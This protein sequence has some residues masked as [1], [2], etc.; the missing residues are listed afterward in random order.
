M[1]G[2]SSINVD[3]RLPFS[4]KSGFRDQYMGRPGSN[5]LG[6]DILGVQQ[7]GTKGKK[8]SSFIGSVVCGFERMFG[9]LS[10]PWVNNRT[11]LRWGLF[12]TKAS[13]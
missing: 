9:G 3:F 4:L 2:G 7:L 8:T 11:Q 6:R 13:G 10:I 5:T 12:A 1:A